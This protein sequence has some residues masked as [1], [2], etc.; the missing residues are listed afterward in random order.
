MGF[1]FQFYN[2]LAVLSA[3]ENVEMP[4][5]LAGVTVRRGA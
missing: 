3:A 4:L 5:L 1:V 2:L